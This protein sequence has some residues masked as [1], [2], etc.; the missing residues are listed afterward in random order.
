MDP[1]FRLLFKLLTR[2]FIVTFVHLQAIERQLQLHKAAD[3]IDQ[4]IAL[5]QEY[6]K[7]GFDP[8]YKG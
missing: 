6:L 3:E 1:K 4:E 2:G 8:D 7:T 5:Y